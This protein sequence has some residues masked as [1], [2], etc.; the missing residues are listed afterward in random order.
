MRISLIL[1]VVT[2][3]I[4][5]CNSGTIYQSF[6]TIEDK[7]SVSDPINF[8]VNVNEVVAPIDA[9]ISLRYAR[10]YPYNNIYLRYQVID[11]QGN[12]LIDKLE[13]VVF[14]VPKTGKPLGSGLGDVYDLDHALFENYTFEK[15]GAYQFVFT[16]FMRSDSL[17]GVGRL[18]LI[19][20]QNKPKEN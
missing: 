4:S 16:Q 10:D 9:M 8:Q 14:F 17:M 18:G 2:L 5:A 20:Q 7:W 13:E 1:I 6:V 19:L 11:A 3:L 15:P 12:Q